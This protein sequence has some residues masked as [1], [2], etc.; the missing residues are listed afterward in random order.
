MMPPEIE[1]MSPGSLVNSLPSRPMSQCYIYIYT[2]TQKAQAVL[3]VTT[4]MNESKV[5]NH[6]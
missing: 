1:P 3:A 2:H 4:I 6:G 5:G